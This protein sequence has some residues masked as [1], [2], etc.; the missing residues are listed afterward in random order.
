MC[1]C[2]SP[3]VAKAQG[4][5]CLFISYPKRNNVP[6]GFCYEKTARTFSSK[7]YSA[8][9]TIACI[10]STSENLFMYPSLSL[11]II[12]HIFLSAV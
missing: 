10:S 9:M 11:P 1:T 6:K 5:L 3:D 12:K 8:K 2:V 7:F 4:V